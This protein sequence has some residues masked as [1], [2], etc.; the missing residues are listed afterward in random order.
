MQSHWN[1]YTSIDPQIRAL[2]RN[3]ANPNRIHD[4]QTLSTGQSNENFYAFTA[5]VDRLSTVSRDHY[6]ITYTVTNSNVILA[7]PLAITL[8]LLT[9]MLAAWGISRRLK[10]F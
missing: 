5:A 9:G 1:T 6:T 10:D 4:A 2:A 7:I 3:T 8:F